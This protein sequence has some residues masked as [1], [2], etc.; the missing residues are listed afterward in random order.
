MANDT[1][2]EA[3]KQALIHDGWAILAEHFRMQLGRFKLFADLA[4]ERTLAAE[5]NGR[6]ILVEV[7]WI[8]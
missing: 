5:R 4:A 1:I 3:V 6:K 2:H 7:K 8:N